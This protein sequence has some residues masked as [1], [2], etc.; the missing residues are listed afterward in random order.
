MIDKYFIGG[1]AVFFFIFLFVISVLVINCKRLKA[2][3]MVAIE[4]SKSLSTQIELQNYSIEQ[5]EK[6]SEDAEKRMQSALLK[7]QEINKLSQQKI[8]SLH[9]ENVPSKCEESISWGIS[10]AQEMFK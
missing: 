1:V 3:T 7:N 10:K 4:K 5:L 6:E 9:K 2:E 8:S